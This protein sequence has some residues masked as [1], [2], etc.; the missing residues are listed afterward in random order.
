MNSIRFFKLYYLIVLELSSVFSIN[1]NQ[2]RLDYFVVSQIYTVDDSRVKARFPGLDFQ[3]KGSNL[4]LIECQRYLIILVL[5][6]IV[7][8]V[9]ESL[10]HVLGNLRVT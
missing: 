4:A 2:P 7:R 10:F 9:K 6:L 5:T 8:K 1:F 3:V